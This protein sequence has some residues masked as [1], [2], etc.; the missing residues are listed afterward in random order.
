MHEHLQGFDLLQITS[1]ALALADWFSTLDKGKEVCAVFFD[2]Q[3]TFGTVSNL[4]LI[5]KLKKY[6]SIHALWNG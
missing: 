1:T 3:K 4:P 5:D 2:Y 6:L